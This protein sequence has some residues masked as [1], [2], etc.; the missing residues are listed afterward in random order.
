MTTC[1]PVV[2]VGD[3]LLDRDVTGRATRLC[4]DAPVPV[5]DELESHP[6]PGGAAL[7][8]ALAA[9]DGHEVHLIAAI[10]HDAA[11]E[12]LRNLLEA[13]DVHLVA[14]D[15]GGATPEKIRLLAE[16]RPMIRWDRGGERTPPARLSES[17]L[18][19][20]EQAAVVIVSDYG[21]GITADEGLRRAIRRR[22]RATL[23]DPHPR[24]SQAPPGVTLITP[25]L[26]EL[27]SFLSAQSC[28]TGGP[29][30]RSGPVGAGTS[31]G[32]A[33]DT[34][35]GVGNLRELA[36]QA[37]LA[38]R[39]WQARAVAVTLGPAG[40]LLVDG[41]GPPLAVPAAAVS[42]GDPC[43]AGDR[44][45]TAVAGA[46]VGGASLSEAVTDG[47]ATAAGF[48][49]R[50]GA[51][52]VAAPSRGG[53]EEGGRAVGGETA[54]G[55]AVALAAR[56]RSAGGTVVVAGGC[57]DLLHAGHLSLLEAASRLGDCLIVAMNSDASIRR[58]KGDGRPVVPEPDRVALVA[59]LAC[60]DAVA[61][62]A[63]DS[64]ADL[65]GRLR[66]HVFVKGG[67]YASR[68]LPEAAAVASWGGQA[69]VVPYLSGRSTSGL[70][71]S[72]RH[73]G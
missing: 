66:P 18:T 43:G 28:P 40:A 67:D 52:L 51:R 16:G 69:V 33:A 41:D 25:N 71:R 68:V 39:L 6:R 54:G 58:L 38:R 42:G 2:V 46:L 55:D 1:S 73:L 35:G 60:V 45:V 63:E 17:A 61:V 50:G 32:A 57:F 27:R 12:E 10:G 49:R 70:L 20:V 62:F 7:A 22:R 14:V 29:M 47:V 53:A 26:V 56:V 21:R 31:G 30:D 23:W 9:A 48:V 4:P 11:G 5:L 13:R 34:A 72:A 44:F 64:P 36:D 3:A 24:G 15:T 19:A 37:G 8:A 65:L 59:G